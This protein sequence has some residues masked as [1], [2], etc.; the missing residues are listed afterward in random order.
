MKYV[1]GFAYF[2]YDFIVGDSIVLALGGVGALVASYVVVALGAAALAEI[3][4]PIVVIATI[5]S[6]LIL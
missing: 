3:I 2:W 1:K 5:V 6:S 4:L